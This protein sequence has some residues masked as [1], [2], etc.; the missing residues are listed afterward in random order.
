MKSI[1]RLKI[2]KLELK[3]DCLEALK[4]ILF[5]AIPLTIATVLSVGDIVLI[6]NYSLEV[7]FGILALFGAGFVLWIRTDDK[8]DEAHKLMNN[9]DLLTEKIADDVFKEMKL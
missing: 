8:K 4:L 7:F 1:Y 3:Q 5:C 9:L 2:D 6:P